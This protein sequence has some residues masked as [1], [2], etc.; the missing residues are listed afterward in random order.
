M[1]A[2][3]N[4]SFKVGESKV[5]EEYPQLG[6]LVIGLNRLVFAFRAH[7]RADQCPTGSRPAG[8]G[9]WRSLAPSPRSCCWFCGRTPCLRPNRNKCGRQRC[10]VEIR[11]PLSGYGVTFKSVTSRESREAGDRD[12]FWRKADIRAKSC[13]SNGPTTD[14]CTAANGCYSITSSARPKSV[15]GILRPSALAV[16]RLM[17][18]SILVGCSTGKSAGF[19]P[20]NI[21]ST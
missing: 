11:P 16:F 7:G 2:G 12:R 15:A 19:A 9:F 10:M 8:C 21:L 6:G 3:P 20:R 4:L 5:S 18:T 13:G 1:S 17:T 14:S